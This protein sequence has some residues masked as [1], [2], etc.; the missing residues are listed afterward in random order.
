MLT[1]WFFWVKMYIIYRSVVSWE[2]EEDSPG[3]SVPN[4]D[5]PVDRYKEINT[6]NRGGER[7]EG[8]GERGEGRGEGS[9]GGE[10]RGERREGD[11]GEGRGDIKE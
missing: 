7:G 3:N 4:I 9:G 1:D 11:R 2:L 8:R 6:S 5:K 10:S